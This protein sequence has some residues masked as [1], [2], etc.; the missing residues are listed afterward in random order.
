MFEVLQTLGT[1]E[2]E[3]IYY[4]FLKDRFHRRDYSF[5][6]GDIKRSNLRPSVQAILT[7]L[8]TGKLKRPTHRPPDK[9]TDVKNM[10]RALRVLDIERSGWSRGRREAA[11]TEAASQL[12]C[13]KKTIQN[14]LSE[15]EAALRNVDPEP[16]EWL[17]N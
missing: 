10:R 2:G 16:L 13:S 17:R 1:P 9:D 14:A 6:V 4:G 15:Y 8:I 3:V 5:L 11:V 7:H 12:K